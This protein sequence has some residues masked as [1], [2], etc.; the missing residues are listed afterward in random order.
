LPFEP[1]EVVA[2]GHGKR[3]E[4]F[5]RL[6]RLVKFDGDSA[7]F[8]VNAGRK[9]VKLLIHNLNGGFDQQPGLFHAILPAAFEN[10]RHL[11]APMGF[12]KSVIAFGELAEMSNQRISVY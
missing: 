10:L 3:Q 1:L 5:Q 11:A 2:D 8:N 9:V 7:A 12:V 4:L 6:L